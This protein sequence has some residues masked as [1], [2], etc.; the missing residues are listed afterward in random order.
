[1]EEVHAIGYGVKVCIMTTNSNLARWVT[2][3]DGN[4][5]K[6]LGMP[7]RI[8]LRLMPLWPPALLVDRNATSS[9]V[10]QRWPK[11]KFHALREQARLVF[12]VRM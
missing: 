2:C 8:V 11:M 3:D 10:E 6:Y 1:V 5:L 12:Q 9:A 4:A 7:T